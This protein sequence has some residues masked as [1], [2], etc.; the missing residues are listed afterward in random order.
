[1]TGPVIFGIIVALLAVA[2][3][4]RKL[5]RAKRKA[6]RQVLF[7]SRMPDDS[8]EILKKNVPLYRRLPADLQ[9]Q[10]EGH[11]MVLLEEL[12]FE[13]HNGLKMTKEIRTTI[14]GQAA[15]LLLN[16]KQ[17]FPETLKSVIVYPSAYSARTTKSAGGIHTEAKQTVLGQSW[18]AGCIVL[19]W[20]NSRHT[21]A[22]PNDGHNLIL[23]EFAHQLDQATGAADGTPILR[24]RDR[25][26]E[27]RKALASTYADFLDDT[28]RG[29]KTV[30]DEYGA[31]NPAEFFA[32][33][34]ETFFEKPRQLRKKRPELY[35]EL[36]K[37]YRT[38]PLEW[39]K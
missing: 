32:V 6:R 24:H 36:T 17:F 12:S 1:M 22:N 8:K 34:T 5:S 33:A 20:D 15:F 2:V 14:A 7:Q 27:W 30:M 21:A 28:E 25:Y 4:M 26:P 11:A 29:R 3:T 37:Y 35:A 9:L 18:D 19:A 16:Q 31:T 23:H 10:V 39:P 38:D 13:G